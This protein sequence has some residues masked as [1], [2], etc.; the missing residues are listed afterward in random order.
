[1]PVPF[2]L[3]ISL[4]YT[5]T[6]RG[7]RFVSFISLSSML[8]IALGVT[9]LI[10]VLSVMNGFQNELRQR[11]LGVASHIEVTGENNQLAH[12]Q[13]LQT[14]ITR[15]VPAVQHVAP[16][17]NAQGMIGFGQNVQGTIVR[18]ILPAQE[19]QVA[20]MAHHMVIGKLDKL[21]A[22]TYG[23]ILGAEL[24]NT[25]GIGIGDK[26][27]LLA[28]QAQFTPLGVMP[29]LKQFTLVGVFQVGM[30]EYDA[31]LALIHMEDAR[32]LYRMNNMVSG[33]R[34]KL[35]D[36]FQAPAVAQTIER[37]L[38]QTTPQVI[39]RDWGMQHANFFKAVQLEKRVMF[40]ILTL[41]IAVAAFNIVSTMVMVVTDKR[42]DIAILR[43]LGARPNS[44][45]WIFMMQGMLIGIIG[46]ISGVVLGVLIATHI[47]TIVPFI[48]HLFQVQFL[49]KDVY[50]IS[51]LPSQLVWHDVASIAL[52]SLML[53]FIAT[54]YPSWRAT[55]TNPAD[56]LRH[57]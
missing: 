5:R 53:S 49:A 17:I 56:V 19:E 37:M 35:Y 26:V 6:R 12:W 43:T 27:T 41:I 18:G 38:N 50:Y 11:I 36:L 24:V 48:E 47:D 46:T 21:Q 9:A 30:Y 33:L 45:L 3:A 40:I 16:Y 54:M 8:G 13:S 44:I 25:L 4:R 20:D 52:M 42:A 57:E 31:G 22:N 28:P 23:I 51:E 55:K 32:T 1:M 10:V 34:L 14:T 2:E 29:R 7:D 39:V 15:H